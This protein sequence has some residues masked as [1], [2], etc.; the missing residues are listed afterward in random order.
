MK[1]SS[2]LQL[3][4]RLTSK[5]WSITLDSTDIK[6]TYCS[7]NKF[8]NVCMKSHKSARH[9]YKTEK[10]SVAKFSFL[11]SIS[12]VTIQNLHEWDL[13]SKACSLSLF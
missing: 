4:K 6:I 10:Y 2:P 7:V 1:T 3:Q 12:I 8:E 11:K 13:N 5:K 9:I